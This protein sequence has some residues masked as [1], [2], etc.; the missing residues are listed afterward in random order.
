VKVVA[1][2]HFPSEHLG[3][4]ASSL[5]SRGIE[6]EYAD[7]WLGGPAPEISSTGGL[8]FLG[9]QM[10]ANDDLPYIRAELE[11]IRRAIELGKPLL[12]VCLGAQLIAKA[13]GARVHANPVKEIGWHP[14]HWTGAAR[15]LGGSDTVFHWHGETFELP[16]GAELLAS[17]EACHNQAYRIGGAVYGLQF[18]LEATPAM[19]EEWLTQDANCGELREIA[20]PIDPQA[21]AGRLEELSAQVFGRWCDLCGASC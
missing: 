8:I 9:G 18:H 7:L 5:A 21:N 6:Y 17:S 19:I 4:I 10:S 2:R 15:P 20:G 1:F 12:G 13:L 16:A 3:R 11:L 14:V